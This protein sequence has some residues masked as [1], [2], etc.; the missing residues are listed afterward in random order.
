MGYRGFREGPRTQLWLNSISC[1]VLFVPP[2]GCGVNSP[3]CVGVF[4]RHRTFLKPSLLYSVESCPQTS[5]SDK[6]WSS[7]HH[8]TLSPF[9]IAFCPFIKFSDFLRPA[10][11]HLSLGVSLHVSAPV[12]DSAVTEL[13]SLLFLL[14]LSSPE[15]SQLPL[16]N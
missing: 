16:R 9:V 1:S 13:P 5:C 15:G 6:A 2:H 14:C 3:L 11:S 12:K 4:I 10:E 8:R 7:K